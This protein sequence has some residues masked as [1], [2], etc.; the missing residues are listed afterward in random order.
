M[1]MPLIRRLI[2]ERGKPPSQ[3]RDED[4][5]SLP[6]ILVISLA[7]VGGSVALAARTGSLGFGAAFQ[8][9]TWDARSIAQF[10]LT[11]LVSRLNQER[12]RGLLA[13]PERT[14]FETYSASLWNE[15]SV[16][17][18]I[19]HANPC[20]TDSSGNQLQPDL[21]SI[22]PSGDQSKFWYVN[23]R[24][25]VSS[26][27][28]DAVGKFR[29]VDQTFRMGNKQ[30]LAALP[31]PSGKTTA[32][33]NIEA[34]SINNGRD[35]ARTVLEAVLDI[36][37]KCCRVTL[38]SMKPEDANTPR[39]GN[40]D[41]TRRFSPDN[42]FGA[43]QCD[44]QTLNPNSFGLVWGA[45]GDGGTF[46]TSGTPSV[47]IGTDGTCDVNRPSTGEIY[48]N[49]LACVSPDPDLCTSGSYNGLSPEQEK[50]E[51]I[52]TKLPPAP[53]YYPSIL[54]APTSP[55]RAL[56]ACGSRDP[57]TR[58]IESCRRLSLAEAQTTQ[59]FK[60]CLTSDNCNRTYINGRASASIPDYCNYSDANNGGDGHLHCVVKT[61][62]MKNNASI[63]FFTGY[64]T[65]SAASSYT[66]APIRV[67]FP[68][69]SE[70]LGGPV[71]SQ[72]G[73]SGI[74]H[75]VELSPDPSGADSGKCRGSG[76]A[77][78]IT[79]LSMFGCNP[80]PEAELPYYGIACGQQVLKY[81]GTPSSF[82][83]FSY[84]PKGSMEFAGTTNLTG[85]F[86]TDDLTG[87]GNPSFQVTSTGVSEVFEL[88]GINPGEENTCRDSIYGGCEPYT[89]KWDFVVR[90]IRRIS[91]R[92]G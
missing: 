10:G 64:R 50:V 8:K 34:I 14:D 36:T 33:L 7:L 48:I 1:N 73:N 53:E 47:C 71:L 60:F 28:V 57:D 81:N 80:T 18:D 16:D 23:S 78:K 30:E 74:E 56:V 21:E 55:Y 59:L 41:Y 88:L 40:N 4:G 5:Y 87:R 84:F 3:K 29:L 12:N 24:G 83:Y 49:P 25:E 42:P 32:V 26:S 79:Q 75:C 69:S 27:D 2:P 70:S 6:L 86:W 45:D 46:N 54:A 68:Q 15:S 22:Y 38:G 61:I 37:P 20:A 13:A 63:Q 90:G 92:F 91:Y 72:A 85:V 52:D 39:H 9:Q 51:P 89:P 67:Y 65:S 76:V 35:G 58:A 66:P 11:T 77:A 31:Q 17:F 44:Q 43:S 62:V 82:G 19:M